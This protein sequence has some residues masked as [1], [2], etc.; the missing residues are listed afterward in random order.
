MEQKTRNKIF[1]STIILVSL[2]TIIFAGLSIFNV[3]NIEFRVITQ[4]TLS[5]T[6]LLRGIQSIKY[7]EQKLLGYTLVGV[8]CFLLL[9]MFF[10]IF[11]EF[12]K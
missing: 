4:A 9:V 5:L 3:D 10:T 8:S 1:S 2:I 11:A 6:M 12:Y 7:N